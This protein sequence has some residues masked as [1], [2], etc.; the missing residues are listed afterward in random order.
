[1]K[2]YQVIIHYIE[3]VC[4]IVE[5]DDEEAAI[6]KVAKDIPGSCSIEYAEAFE[7]KS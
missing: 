3:E 7:V 5:A 4:D 6:E 1:M 2:K